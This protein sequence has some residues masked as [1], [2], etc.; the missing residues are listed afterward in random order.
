MQSLI[1]K[2]KGL[3]IFLLLM[4]PPVLL[5]IFIRLYG[6]NVL[7]GDDWAFVLVIE[8]LHAGNLT[9]GDLN[10][11]HNE[12]RMLFPNLIMLLLV[13]L[14]DYN[15][16]AAMYFSWGLVLIESI[17][18]FHMFRQDFGDSMSSLLKFLPVCWLLF[19]F[20]QFECILWS[21]VGVQIY[22]SALGFV[23]SIYL[24]AKSDRLPLVGALCAGIISS[25]SF[26]NGLLV[27]PVGLIF[28]VVSREKRNARHI[29]LW[30]VAGAL[31]WATYLHA[32]AAIPG[33]SGI[34]SGLARPFDFLWFVILSIGSPLAFMKSSASGMGAVM[35]LFIVAVFAGAVYADEPAKRKW[36]ALILF[37]LGSTILFSLGRV[38]QG[39]Y[40]ALASRYYPFTV[41]GIIGVYMAVL[42]SYEKTVDA[43]SKW[44]ALLYGAVLSIV[45][46]GLISGYSS[47]ILR[48]KET[49]E[50]RKAMVNHLTA[51]R[52]TD[53]AVMVHMH[54]D[55]EE[56]RRRAGVLEKLKY[57]VFGN[58]TD[59]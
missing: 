29:L 15:T 52:E 45:F 36:I 26:A 47:G 8:K 16:I 32:L 39:L 41:L 4:V 46:V 44:H 34:L 19:S 22:L 55:V 14:T 40:A 9:F 24:L 17:L 12:H 42:H 18:I 2:K 59:N 13:Y 21:L 3:L 33:R 51:Y 53:A 50:T 37:S 49:S 54:P 10:G 5:L 43:D 1:P 57:N 48:G 7:Y 30:T 35:C 11:L 38:E 23:A 28:L 27:W 6:V 58:N 20:R 25:F 31:V 56:L